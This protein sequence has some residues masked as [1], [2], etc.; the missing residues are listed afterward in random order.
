MN[1][2]VGFILLV[3]GGNELEAFWLFI[4]LCRHKDYMLMGFYEDGFPMLNLVLSVF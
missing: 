1:F 3:N 2:I 4:E